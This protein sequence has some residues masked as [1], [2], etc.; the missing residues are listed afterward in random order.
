MNWQLPRW[1][2][3]PISKLV[4]GSKGFF[5]RI[6]PSVSACLGGFRSTYHNDFDLVRTGVPIEQQCIMALSFG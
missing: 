3:S 6:W 4:I 5:Y 1:K 2:P